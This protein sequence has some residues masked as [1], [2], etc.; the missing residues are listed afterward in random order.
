MLIRR[1]LPLSESQISASDEAGVVH[2]SG[3]ACVYDTLSRP[4]PLSNGRKF[5]ERISASAFQS[6]LNDPANDIICT[7]NHDTSKI[8][9]R[10]SSKTLEIF[11]NSHALSVRCQL[12][13]TS[14][15]ADLIES[16]KRGDVLGMSF[17]FDEQEPTWESESSPDGYPVC[18]IHRAFL[19]EVCFTSDPAYLS[20]SVA[21]R[22][23]DSIRFGTSQSAGA[24]PFDVRRNLLLFGINPKGL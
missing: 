13:K 2:L 18:T 14:Y 1:Y 20:S 23:A 11:N 22:N 10:T 9:G 8:L 16:V 4:L 17:T 24:V 19:Y 7:V 6:T 5:R 3:N 12:P 15:A 21:M